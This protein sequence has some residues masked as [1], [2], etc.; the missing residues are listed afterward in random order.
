M[1]A[2]RRLR[3]QVLKSSRLSE[4]VHTLSMHA[5]RGVAAGGD[6]RVLLRD[7]ELVDLV[8][9]RLSMRERTEDHE[10]GR[11]EGSKAEGRGTLQ[12]LWFDAEW[13]TEHRRGQP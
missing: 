13:R 5:D 7:E 1:R 9:R 12:G 2:D 4:T 8:A 3:M 10:S 6:E 11:R